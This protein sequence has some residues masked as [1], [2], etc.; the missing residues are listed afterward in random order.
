MSL[1][2]SMELLTACCQQT[3]ATMITRSTDQRKMKMLPVL[4]LLNAIH[5][6]HERRQAIQALSELDDRILR[7]I[8]IDR[9]AIPHVVANHRFP[10]L[11]PVTSCPSSLTPAGCST[12]P[13]R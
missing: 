6:W 7:D 5:R 12:S 11:Y 9:G 2:S 10:D 13:A 3:G 1:H 8:G 4:K